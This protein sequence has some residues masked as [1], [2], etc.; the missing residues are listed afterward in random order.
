M[1]FLCYMTVF[2]FEISMQ[3]ILSRQNRWLSHAELTS[4]A[5]SVNYWMHLCHFC[6]LLNGACF[7]SDVLISPQTQ[8]F[9]QCME[10]RKWLTHDDV[11]K[12][13]HFVSRY[14]P[15]VRGNHR[16]PVDSP[17]KGQWR[18][19]LMVA[20]ILT[21]GWANNWDAGDLRRHRAHD[22]ATVMFWRTTYTIL[23]WTISDT[24][25][26]V[27]FWDCHRYYQRIV[28]NVIK[29]SLIITANW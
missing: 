7:V 5:V 28:S 27:A 26:A 21:S 16:S 9:T 10:A 3:L 20:L 18:R 24:I 25:K 4:F 19:A 13:K 2:G 12:W 11:I 14:W 6:E 29:W 22:D 15:C 23:L 1:N 8:T 17:H